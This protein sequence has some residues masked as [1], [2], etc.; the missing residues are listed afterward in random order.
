MALLAG[1]IE[2][3][4]APIRFGY[5]TVAQIPVRQLV[6]VAGGYMGERAQSNWQRLLGCIEGQ[7]RKIH[8]DLAVFEQLKTESSEYETILKTFNRSQLWAAQDAT[9]HRFLTLPST[10]DGFLKARGV[11][12]TGI[13]LS[14]CPRPWIATSMVNGKFNSTLPRTK[15]GCLSMPLTLLLLKPTSGA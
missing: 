8:V 10:W 3:G 7:L 14:T 6:L 11:A 13:G 5:A 2:A 15:G 9:K 4:K 1:R 12:N